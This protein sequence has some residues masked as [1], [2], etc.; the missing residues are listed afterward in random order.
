VAAARTRAVREGK[1]WVITARNVH[2]RRHLNTHVFMLTRTEPDAPSTTAL[3][4][5][6]VPLK[7][8]GIEVRG[9]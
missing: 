8:P 6:V 3:T 2:H 4:T 5:A 9:I 1:E 7:Q